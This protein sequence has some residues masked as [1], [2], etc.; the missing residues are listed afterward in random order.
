MGERWRVRIY[1]TALDD[2]DTVRRLHPPW[3]AD[4]MCPFGTT[5]CHCRTGSV[6]VWPASATK[7]ATSVAG[8]V[9]LAFRVDT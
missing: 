2:R 7:N 9:L 1:G 6:S 5:L 3:D 4:M 8:S